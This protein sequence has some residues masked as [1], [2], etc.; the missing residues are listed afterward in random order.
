MTV[1]AALDELSFIRTERESDDN[2][3]S[4]SSL[5]GGPNAW[6]VALQ[7]PVG[8]LYYHTVLY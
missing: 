2:N 1:S 3:E 8:V 4:T 7:T 6:Y 5:C